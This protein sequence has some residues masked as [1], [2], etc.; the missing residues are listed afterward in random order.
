MTVKIVVNGRNS[1]PGKLADDEPL[2]A[3]GRPSC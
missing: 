3:T 2:F 1:T